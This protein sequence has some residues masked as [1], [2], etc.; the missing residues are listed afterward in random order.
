MTANEFGGGVNGLC[1]GMF[2]SGERFWIAADLWSDTVGWELAKGDMG[3]FSRKLEMFS[4]LL[5]QS[6]M[7]MGWALYVLFLACCIGDSWST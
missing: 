3:R 7:E 2:D 5:G 1:G 6:K 4:G